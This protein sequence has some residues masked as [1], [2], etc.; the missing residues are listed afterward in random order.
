ML[1]FIIPILRVNE[2]RMNQQKLR[3]FPLHLWPMK[4]YAIICLIKLKIVAKI[5]K[6]MIFNLLFAVC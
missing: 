1:L 3:N 6:K 4:N 5:R 2:E